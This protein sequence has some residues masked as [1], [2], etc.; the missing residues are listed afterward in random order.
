MENDPVSVDIDGQTKNLDVALCIICQL[1]T[2]ESL[3]EK[4]TSY[5]KILNCVEE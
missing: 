2:D 5:E 4:P 1:K 3:V